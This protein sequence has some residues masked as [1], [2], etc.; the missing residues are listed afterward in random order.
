MPGK[1]LSILA[2]II[3][4]ALCVALAVQLPA[5]LATADRRLYDALAG[6]AF[7]EHV[8]WVEDIE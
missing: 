3:L 8:L 5:K 1:S 2:A 6:G 7:G 4:I